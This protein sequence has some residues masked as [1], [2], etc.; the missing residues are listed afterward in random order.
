MTV[1]HSFVLVGRVWNCCRIHS[2][3]PRLGPANQSSLYY[4]NPLIQANPGVLVQ[5]HDVV[6][7]LQY[8]HEFESIVVHGDLKPVG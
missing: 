7:G 5:I 3:G 2:P 4:E 1:I 6:K 8:L